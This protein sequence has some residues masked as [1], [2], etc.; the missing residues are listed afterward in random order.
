[1]Y[2][3]LFTSS[4]FEK[5]LGVISVGQ[6][7]ETEQNVVD[8]ICSRFVEVLEVEINKMSDDP[9]RRTVVDQL[10]YNILKFVATLRG[11]GFTIVHDVD[12]IDIV[13]RKGFALYDAHKAFE[14]SNS[15]ST[16]NAFNKA[17]VSHSQSKYNWKN[18]D[19]LKRIL[20]VVL[21]NCK[22][23]TAKHGELVKTKLD[24]VTKKLEGHCKDFGL[25]SRGMR[26]GTGWLDMFNG[27][28]LQELLTHASAPGQ[29]LSGPGNEVGKGKDLL[30]KVIFLIM[31]G[32]SFFTSQPTQPTLVGVRA[33]CMN[34]SD[35]HGS[36]Y[37]HC[38]PLSCASLTRE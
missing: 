26:D 15:K 19:G 36:C 12:S 31:N 1:M 22:F 8:T 29:L 11:A 10:Q 23:A 16:F 30:D 13:L 20:S 24:A 28:T 2:S 3:D 32:A 33:A 35:V 6:L 7:K 18:D 37:L 9:D 21:V 34:P 38:V 4:D 27:V 25:I 17:A 5:A 14:Q